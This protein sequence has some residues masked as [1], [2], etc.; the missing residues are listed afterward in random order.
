MSISLTPQDI[1]DKLPRES[2]A[3][4]TLKD[5]LKA[6]NLSKEDRRQLK[7]LLR[8]MTHAGQIMRRKGGRYSIQH[9]DVGARAARRKKGPP[10]PPRPGQSPAKPD[11]WPS[12]AGRL[13]AHRDGYGFVILDGEGESD[14]YISPRGMRDAMDGDR[15]MVQILAVKEDGRREGIISEVL[16]RAHRQV[17]GRFER[18]RSPSG[19]FGFVVP[20]NP[21]ILH[22]V[23]IAPELVLNAQEGDLVV[24]E[25]LTYPTLQRNPQGRITRILGVAGD[26]GIDTEM[27]IEQFSLPRT[28]SRE[29]Q[30]VAEALPEQVVAAMTHGRR[31]LRSL[32]T[33]T[34]DGERA[35]DFDDAISIERL[36]HPYVGARAATHDAG[37]PMPPHPSPS[38]AKPEAG[39]S[40]STAPD[41]ARFR[42]WV[43]I[44][45]VAHYVGWDTILDLEARKRG[46]SVYFPD[47]VVPMFPERLSN[48]IC[49]L[50]PHEDRLTLTVE[51][52]FDHHGTRLGYE[53]YESVIRSH[54]R[55]TY[56]QVKEILTGGSVEI[57]KRYAT[58]LADFKA[59]EE[60]CEILRARRMERG[61]IDF[62]LPEPEIILDLQGQTLQ[63]LKEERNLAHRII[64]EFMLSANET[65]AQHLTD[66][67]V[68][69]IYRIHEVPDPDKMMGLNALLEGFG[70]Y[71]RGIAQIQP[72]TLQQVLEQVKDRP[73]EKLVNTVVLRSMKQARYDTTQTGHFGLAMDCYTHFTSPIRRYPDLVIHR[74]VKMT[75]NVGARAATQ[76]ERCS[77]LPAGRQVPPRRSDM[78]PLRFAGANPHM[79]HTRRGQAEPDPR[80][81]LARA[82]PDARFSSPGPSVSVA[83]LSE[84]ARH[85]S[86]RERIA[87]EAER[88]V[89]DIKKARFM[90]DKMGQIYSG[91]ISGVVPYGFFVELDEIFVEGLVRLSSLTD[92]HYLYRE[93]QHS[94]VG[95]GRRRTYRLGDPVQVKVERVDLI[96]YQI[97]LSLANLP[98]SAHVRER[99]VH[100]TQHRKTIGS[101]RKRR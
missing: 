13:S 39:Q 41:G 52:L 49:S 68:P 80:P 69:M 20:Q 44:A 91:H 84:V 92:D 34:I 7:K 33:V 54:E 97:N 73:E 55:M 31:D 74:L 18:G 11:A 71:L 88:K 60:L 76:K 81:A 50:N 47:R 93:A 100:P 26:P 66:L 57:Q 27:I 90:A 5:L 45:D 82:K 1:L 46:N 21:R 28:F 65:V 56:T 2:S 6:L 98:S 61:S 59:M 19:E 16:D 67:N 70:L 36:G 10:M 43:H 3:S 42:L 25:L 38:L 37:P 96:Q 62:D 17:V 58:L 24:A 94:L 64:E 40:R 99:R 30:M 22:D 23:Y 79:P 14:I 35:R 78:G 12:M 4:T 75:L 85:C 101:K 63:I 83:V 72:K 9:S 48:G 86:E 32:K 87:M 29:C 89:V 8:N 51:M 77:D 53:I 15:V 95:V